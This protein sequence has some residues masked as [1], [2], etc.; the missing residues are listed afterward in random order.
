MEILL[1]SLETR[2][3]E[4]FYDE[5]D[6]EVYANVVRSSEEI[7]FM[8]TF[9]KVSQD[10]AATKLKMVKKLEKVYG[11]SI[12]IDSDSIK[13]SESINGVPLYSS[14]GLIGAIVGLVGAIVKAIGAV[15]GFFVNLIFK[16]FIKHPIKRLD[17]K[18]VYAMYKYRK[19]HK[20]GKESLDQSIEDNPPNIK[21]KNH[22]EQNGDGDGGDEIGD[23]E[24]ECQ[25]LDNKLHDRLKKT[26]ASFKNANDMSK[27]MFLSTIYTPRPDFGKMNNLGDTVTNRASTIDTEVSTILNGVA[28]NNKEVVGKLKEFEKGNAE[29]VNHLKKE[30]SDTKIKEIPSNEKEVDNQIEIILF[31]ISEPSIMKNMFEF[32]RRNS[33]RANKLKGILP[34]IKANSEK[35]LNTLKSKENVPE[36]LKSGVQSVSKS[37]QGFQAQSMAYWK[38]SILCNDLCGFFKAA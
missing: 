22:E 1:D 31:N 34:K 10:N 35:L 18:R 19:K 21:N 8:N 16:I 11:N 13:S 37:V 23:F 4:E 17:E 3:S 24:K 26:C 20:H 25:E 7:H 6:D 38:I 28:N 12:F 32:T 30:L 36:E 15:I 29:Y 2:S 9:L 5:Y 33:E 27:Q 14:E